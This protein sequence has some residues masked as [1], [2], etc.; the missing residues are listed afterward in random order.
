[1]KF[2]ENKAICENLLSERGEQ[3]SGLCDKRNVLTARHRQ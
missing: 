3:L 2:I 1:V